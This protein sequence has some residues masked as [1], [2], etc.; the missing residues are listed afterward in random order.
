MTTVVSIKEALNE[1]KSL[2]FSTYLKCKSICYD[3]Y[4]NPILSGFTPQTAQKLWKI[5][6]RLYVD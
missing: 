5:V 4:D 2:D 6:S 1:L 3:S